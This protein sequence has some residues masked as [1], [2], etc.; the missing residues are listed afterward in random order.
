MSV[1]GARAGWVDAT[2]A[3]EFPQLRLVE[4]TVQAT[5]GRSTREGRAWLR[6]LADRF[7]GAQVVALRQQP[8]PHAYRV[9]HRHIGLD[10]DVDRTPVEAAAMQRLLAGGF[11]ATGRVGDALLIALIETGVPVWAL[12]DAAL[13]GPLGLRVAGDDEQLGCGELADDLPP[14]R[15]VVC[16]ARS[17]AAVLFGAED[18]ARAVTRRTRRLRLYS[19]AVAGVPA[20]HVEEALDLCLDALGR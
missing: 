20:V 9:F 8:I 10:P 6:H 4:L 16:D 5:P 14:G 17:P 2:L 3:E 7:G 18:P 1:A 12:D 13:L 19:V 11:P 15:L